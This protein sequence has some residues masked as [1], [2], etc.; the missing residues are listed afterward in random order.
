MYYLFV[1]VVGLGHICAC[2][3]EVVAAAKGVMEKGRC[4]LRLRSRGKDGRR[5][6]PSL[7][8]QLGPWCS[9]DVGCTRGQGAKV[10]T[11]VTGV[12]A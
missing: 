9:W 1:P 3:T 4:C 6:R 2:S 5:P 10:V 7:W 8:P 11:A 12:V